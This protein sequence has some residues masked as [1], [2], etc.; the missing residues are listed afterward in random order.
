MTKKQKLPKK[1]LIYDI[2]TT[3]NLGYIWAKYEQNVL[4]FVEE[5][6]L[7]S[8]AY[9]W[10]GENKTIAV[11]T[12]NFTEEAL[13]LRLHQLFSEADVVIAHNGDKFDQRK[14]NAKFLEYGLN[15]PASYESI[16]TLKV[17]RKYFALNSH[18][19]DDLG[20]ILKIGNK[21]NTGGFELWL[22]CMR[23]DKRS[24]QKMLAYNKQDV[25]LLEKVY[26][27][28]LPWINNHPSMSV[29]GKPDSCP[30][31]AGGPL[32]ARGTRKTTKTGV[33]QRFQCT[34]CG[35]WCTSRTVDKSFEKPLYVN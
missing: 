9:K 13:V 11:G 5:W 35:G 15:P 17:S 30:K 10:Y 7:L 26:K 31:C 18:K 8:F 12:N 33:Y 34:N 4:K 32:Q 29:L 1:I 24:W 21:L 19:L 6:S 22:G 3:P 20:S 27:R 25:V 23:G 16:D 28:L 2:E 14:V